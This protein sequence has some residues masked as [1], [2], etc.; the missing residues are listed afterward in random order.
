MT[1]DPLPFKR[2]HYMKERG[3]PAWI[4]IHCLR[5]HSLLLLYQKDGP[6][7][8]KRCYLDRI[9]LPKQWAELCNHPFDPHSCPELSCSFCRRLIGLPFVYEKENR[10]S[11]HLLEETFMLELPQ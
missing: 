3:E 11:F 10:P 7:P 5:C 9:A 6:G 4:R 8:L 2:D 1:D